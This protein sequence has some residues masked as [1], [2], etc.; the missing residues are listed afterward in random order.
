[1][2]RMLFVV[3]LG[4]IKELLNILGWIYLKIKR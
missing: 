3:C 2:S 1:M 4:K